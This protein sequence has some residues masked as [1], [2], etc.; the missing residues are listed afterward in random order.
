MITS[1]SLIIRW[2]N[3][4]LFFKYLYQPLIHVRSLNKSDFEAKRN[5]RKRLLAAEREGGAATELYTKTIKTKY[6]VTYRT[7]PSHCHHTH[8][9]ILRTHRHPHAHTRTS[10]NRDSG[11]QFRSRTTSAH[12]LHFWPSHLCYLHLLLASTNLP[13]TANAATNTKLAPT[14]MTAAAAATTAE[15]IESITEQKDRAK[16]LIE[17]GSDLLLDGGELLLKLLP[18]DRLMLFC[19]LVYIFPLPISFLLDRILL[20]VYVWFA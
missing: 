18:S 15:A 17:V 10:N 7:P 9:D 5:A 8:T 20:R 3:N 11:I 2:C 1:S 16:W 12:S 13:P 6:N 14:N 19:F 4:W